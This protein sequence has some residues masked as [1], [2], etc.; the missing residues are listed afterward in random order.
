[1]QVRAGRLA[2]LAAALA[3]GVLVAAPSLAGPEP[4]HRE[5]PR[6]PTVTRTP[7]QA[8]PLARDLGS[9]PDHPPGNPPSCLLPADS[10]TKPLPRPRPIEPETSCELPDFCVQPAVDRPG[11]TTCEPQQRLLEGEI[12]ERVRPG[13]RRR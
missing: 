2:G 1:M 11:L 10:S 7:A 12:I 4:T 9:P 3:A 8:P 13:P 6:E 5:L